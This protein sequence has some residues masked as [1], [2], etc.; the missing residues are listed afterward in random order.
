[1]LTVLIVICEKLF[2]DNLEVEMRHG[3]FLLTSFFIYF[4]KIFDIY[5]D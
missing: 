3:E 2:A 1:M 4:L 5:H